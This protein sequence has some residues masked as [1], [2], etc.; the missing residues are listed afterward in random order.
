MFNSPERTQHHHPASLDNFKFNIHN[1]NNF[2]LNTK[3]WIVSKNMRAPKFLIPAGPP[4]RILLTYIC[5][6]NSL[7]CL[8]D[9]IAG[10]ILGQRYFGRKVSKGQLFNIA[11]IFY[12]YWLRSVPFRVVQNIGEKL[13]KAD[14]SAFLK[15]SAY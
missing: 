3:G 9:V 6:L 1:T 4:K 12:C 14:I 5:R 15:L 10:Q 8:Q 13:S 11:H 2:K 7:Q